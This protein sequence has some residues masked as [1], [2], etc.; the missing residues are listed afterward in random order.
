[1]CGGLS[2]SRILLIWCKRDERKRKM[3]NAK[4]RQR[5]RE[6]EKYFGYAAFACYIRSLTFFVTDLGSIS[7]RAT[8]ENW[9]IENTI[10]FA[11]L[12]L[13]VQL[14]CFTACFYTAIVSILSRIV[15][16]AGI[17]L[18]CLANSQFVLTGKHWFAT[19][20][21]SDPSI[22]QHF[23]IAKQSHAIR[24]YEEITMHKFQQCTS[25]R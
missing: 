18:L 4:V 15:L 10:W 11:C 13:W 6:S 12:H 20:K 17:I 16:I 8:K 1:M 19:T 22:T 5:K 2:C 7:R 9:T 24:Y 14:H 3:Q 21:K 25:N 23:Y